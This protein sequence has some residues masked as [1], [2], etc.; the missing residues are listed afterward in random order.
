VARVG[1]ENVSLQTSV[2][3]QVSSVAIDPTTGTLMLDTDSLGE[4]EMSDVERVL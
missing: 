3:A 4:I 2:A 1:S